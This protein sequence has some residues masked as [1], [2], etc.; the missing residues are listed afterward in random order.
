M[1]EDGSLYYAL[2]KVINLEFH[3]KS[4]CAYYG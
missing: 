2:I 4:N 3:H 1:M